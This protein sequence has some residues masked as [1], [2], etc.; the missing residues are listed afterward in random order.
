M[1]LAMDLMKELRKSYGD[2]GGYGSSR[3]DTTAFHRS[4]NLE[5][6]AK[7]RVKSLDVPAVNNL[8]P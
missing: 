1:E 6:G 4:W 5:F 2:Y 7:A 8:E 3:R